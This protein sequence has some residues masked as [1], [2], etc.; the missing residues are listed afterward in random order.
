MV[1]ELKKYINE[2][3]KLFETKIEDTKS[4]DKGTKISIKLD[5]KTVIINNANEYYTKLSEKI[6]KLLEDNN[7]M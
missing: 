3:L 6:E 4:F 7:K 1:S 5:G 2:E